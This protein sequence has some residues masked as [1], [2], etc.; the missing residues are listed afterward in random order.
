[1]VRK[2]NIRIYLETQ[3]FFTI[4]IALWMALKIGYVHREPILQNLRE[5]G[6]HKHFALNHSIK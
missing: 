2:I 4:L 6:T 1:M 3:E 5:M